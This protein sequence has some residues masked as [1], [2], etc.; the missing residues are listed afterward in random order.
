MSS[1]F[2]PTAPDLILP[3]PALVTLHFFPRA[4]LLPSTKAHFQVMSLVRNRAVTEQGAGQYRQ[5]GR[6]FDACAQWLAWHAYTSRPVDRWQ[7]APTLRIWSAH[8]VPDCSA[9]LLQKAH[10]ERWRS[11]SEAVEKFHRES[12]QD[13]ASHL[14]PSKGI[15]SLPVDLQT[16]PAENSLQQNLAH[17][18]QQS[19]L[20]RSG[21]PAW[22]QM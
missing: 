6:E 15:A 13:P 4:N 18:A 5:S 19:K 1:A 9:Q 7:N 12:L 8:L 17:H 2:F 21:N 10:S 20:L 22:R 3:Q 14:A 11:W 16:V